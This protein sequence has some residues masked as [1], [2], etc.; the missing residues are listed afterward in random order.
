MGGGELTLD[1]A[2]LPPPVT[3]SGSDDIVGRFMG[4]LPLQDAGL[5]MSKGAADMATLSSLNEPS[6]LF[7]LRTRFYA[8]IPYTYT[9]DIVIAVNPYQWLHHLYTEDIR[10]EYLIFGH[11]GTDGLPPHVYSTSAQAFHGM[12][13][14]C[15]N[16]AILVSGESGAGKTETVKILMGHL[17][18]IAS[19]DDETVIRR[20]LESNPLLESFGNAKTVRNDN[21]SRFGKY[22]ELQ[23]SG[24]HRTAEQCDDNTR[25]R[26][27]QKQPQEE[28]AFLVGSCSRHYLLEKS[29]VV[30]QSAGERNFHVFYQ[31]LAAPALVSE[32]VALR[33]S[34]G[35]ILGPLAFAFTAGGGEESIATK[36]EGLTDAARFETTLRALDL[37]GVT[38]SDRRLMWE[39]L[40]GI[41]HLGQ[42]AFVPLSDGG[43]DEGAELVSDSDAGTILPSL[44]AA[45]RLLGCYKVVADRA[46]LE[47]SKAAL[48]TALLERTMS[49]AGETYKI[50][51]RPVQ[52]GEGRSA[53]A[54][55]LYSRLFDWLVQRINDSTTV[56]DGIAGSGEGRTAERSIVRTVGLLDIFGF[57]S[58]KTNRFEQL[59]INYANEKLQQKFTQDVFKSVQAEYEE[60]GIAWEHISFSENQLVLDLIESRMGV[61]SILNEECVRPRGSDSAFCSKLITTHRSHPH[62]VAS[63]FNTSNAVEFG[64]RHYAGVVTYTVKEFLEK[65]R[66]TIP[67]DLATLMANSGNPMVSKLFQEEKEQSDAEAADRYGGKRKAS[68]RGSAL[69]AA[70]VATKFKRQL[71]SLME[72]VGQTQVQYVRC[73]K[74]NSSKSQHGFDLP[75][76][77]EQLRCAGVL[78]AIRISRAAYPNR[79]LHAEVLSRFGRLAAPGSHLGTTAAPSKLLIPSC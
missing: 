25:N 16:Q 68:R 57:E 54:K 47:Q 17:A 35:D 21:S 66:D 39:M 30:S 48:A 63:K 43:P 38:S 67:K 29:R 10:K 23:F 7:N 50:K 77:T 65:N 42:L 45:S 51:Q 31:L 13:D 60:E 18:F 52:A 2:S 53:L 19:S 55:E 49:T 70:T 73:V 41:F 78:E 61:V 40:A 22:I 72:A 56:K 26:S 32:P 71:A 1:L 24:H 12:K 37:I 6:I 11:R 4:K 58:F 79:L 62:F 34:N 28:A 46:P 14:F 75:M 64:V 5:A 3:S 74:P 20:V 69:T 15:R 44:A 27:F 8:G 76:V 9:A 33:A 36:I 59:C